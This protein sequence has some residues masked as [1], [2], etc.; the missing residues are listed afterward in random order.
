MKDTAEI[1]CAAFPLFNGSADTAMAAV[2]EA[3]DA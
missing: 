2:P 1:P 3:G